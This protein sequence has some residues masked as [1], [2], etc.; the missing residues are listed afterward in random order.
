M[1]SS[2]SLASSAEIVP[3]S[4]M[5]SIL[6]RSSPIIYSFVQ[7]VSCQPSAVSLLVAAQIAEFWPLVSLYNE[8]HVI[9]C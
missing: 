1:A 6:S 3:S 8:I 2:S 4:T 5:A 9:L 7:R